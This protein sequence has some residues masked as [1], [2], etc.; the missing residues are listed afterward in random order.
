MVDDIVCEASYTHSPEL[1]WRALTTPEA[2]SAWLMVTTFERAEAGHRFRFTDRPRPFWD[3]ICECEV[4]EA[5]RAQ[6]LVL[7]WGVGNEATSTRVSFVLTPIEGGGTHIAF[8]HAGLK[9]VMG[10][11]MKKGMTRG[12][13]RMVDHRLPFVCA[14][15]AEGRMPSRDDVALRFKNA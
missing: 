13:K 12:W 1:V 7:R 6:R 3:G 5:E 2:L 11:L 4:A 14:E 15:M 10:W 8:R 9:G